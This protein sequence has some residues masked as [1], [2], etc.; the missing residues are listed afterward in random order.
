MEWKSDGAGEV[1]RLR[2]LLLLNQRWQQFWS[3]ISQY[4]I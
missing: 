3:E 4:G 2:S 1:L